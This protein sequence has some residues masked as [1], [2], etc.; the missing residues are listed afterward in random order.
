[1]DVIGTELRRIVDEPVGEE[2]LARAKENVKGR[3]VL[4]F[5]STL[6][7]MNR[8][9]G[10]VLMDVPLLSL[11]EMIAAVDAVDLEAVS[12]LAAELF[13]PERLS[14]AGVGGSEDVFR[15][16]LEKVNGELAAAA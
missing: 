12:E 6:S 16:A 5:E 11:D 13:A 9:G 15:G 2:E 7:R 4:S 10:A 1:M 14:A 3:M 8:L